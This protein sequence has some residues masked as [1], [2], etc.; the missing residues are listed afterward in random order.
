[1]VTDELPPDLDEAP[2]E[3]DEE[4]PVLRGQPYAMEYVPHESISLTHPYVPQPDSY[5]P[6]L[7]TEDEDPYLALGGLARPDAYFG[8]I[9]FDCPT[10]Q[11]K[12]K[13]LDF[14]GEKCKLW[15][16][17]LGRQITRKM[18]CLARLKLAREQGT[19]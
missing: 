9:E 2:P 4:P 14:D 6:I 8:A 18:P 19:I 16:E 10:C 5:A 1:M 17:R 3:L 15:V 12:A 13:T 11:A 7:N